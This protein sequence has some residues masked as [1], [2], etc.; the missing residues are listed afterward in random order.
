M[1]SSSSG[2]PGSDPFIGQQQGG[3]DGVDTVP[4]RVMQQAR[5]RHAYVLDAVREARG[6]TSNFRRA[7]HEAARV[8]DEVGDVHDA[9]G[10]QGKSGRRR[11][12]QIVGS[13]DHISRPKMSYL[14]CSHDSSG[15]A[16]A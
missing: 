9:A 2:A 6:V 3:A 8:G 1:L 10:M 5:R 14:C 12:H 11:R 4:V 16:G 15:S 7:G 13:A